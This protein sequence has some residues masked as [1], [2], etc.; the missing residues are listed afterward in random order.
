V[1]LLEETLSPFPELVR[2][3]PSVHVLAEHGLALLIDEVAVPP[4]EGEAVLLWVEY[5]GDPRLDLEY[6]PP[7]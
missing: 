1:A 2:P 5:V 6:L 3:D 4:L 7:D